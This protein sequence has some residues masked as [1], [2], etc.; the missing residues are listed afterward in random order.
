M[1]F[2]FY[3][4]LNL[5]LCHEC[6]KIYKVKRRNTL[7]YVH[8]FLVKKR[9]KISS[10]TWIINERET[11]IPFLVYH[12]QIKFKI[13]TR[14]NSIFHIFSSTCKNLCNKTCQIVFV[15]EWR[16]IRLTLIAWKCLYLYV[17]QMNDKTVAYKGENMCY[18]CP[19]FFCNQLWK[20]WVTKFLC[21]II[22]FSEIYSLY[23]S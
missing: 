14:R 1:F 10:K 13:Q 6:W 21:F 19:F 22:N 9:Q 2:F 7:R 23:F 18:F 5:L 3:I 4:L 12:Y 11:L 16:N 20:V 8:V 15:W 17:R